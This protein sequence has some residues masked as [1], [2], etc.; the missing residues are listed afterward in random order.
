MNAEV[1]A[2]KAAKEVDAQIWER[3]NFILGCDEME[4]I[5]D[6]IIVPVFSKLAQA[7]KGSGYD[8]DIILMDCESPLDE[9]LYNVGVRLSFNYSESDIE[10]SI[11]ADPSDFS[12]NLSIAGASDEEL[13]TEFK[14]HEV[15]PTIIQ[16]ELSQQFSKL[17]P[18]VD[19]SPSSSRSDS[20]FEKFEPPFRVQYDDN[21]NVS[22]VATTKTLLEAANMGSTFAKMFKKEDAITVLDANDAIVC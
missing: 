21:G 19:Y 15:V 5:T 7:I 6:D 12:F 1:D 2:A 17:F 4:R 22:D 16:K 13:N 11:V 18:K 3:Q 8:M 14:F 10:I 20:A 9:Q